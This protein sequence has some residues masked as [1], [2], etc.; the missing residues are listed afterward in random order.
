MD[1]FFYLCVLCVLCGE[2]F[3]VFLFEPAKDG[4]AVAV[5]CARSIGCRE[6]GRSSICS[7]SS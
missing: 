6:I 7:F 1:L 5:A 2:K 3:F 4:N